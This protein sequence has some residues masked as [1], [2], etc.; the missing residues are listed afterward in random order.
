MSETATE[1]RAILVSVRQS[2]A[3]ENHQEE[4]LEELA[5]LLATLGVEPVER[6][7]VSVRDYRPRYLV[8]SGKADEIIRA[9]DDHDA[10]MIVF[11]NELSPSQQ[12]N[13]ERR[14]ERATLDRQEVILE[15]FGRH[16]GTR[17]AR[18]QVDLAWMQYQLPR[19]TR[20]WTHLS[21]QRGGRRGTRGEGETQ[22]EADRRT[23]LARIDSIRRKLSA[24]EQQ[25]EARR[26]QRTGV[27]VPT[28]AI[29]GYTN[30]G[31]SSLL[32]RLS[33]AGVLV[34][35]QLFA[36]LDP[37]T[38][39]VGLPN[40]AHVLLTDTVGFIRNLPH[41]LVDAF[42]S[43]L[44]E[45]VTADFLINVLDGS[46]PHVMEH[47][48]TTMSVLSDL[49][50]GDK[51]IV[52]VVNKTD[53]PGVRPGDVDVLCSRI[54]ATLHTTCVPCS[55]KTGEG[56]E[57]L[58]EA[59]RDLVAGGF[60]RASYRLPYDRYDLAALAHRTGRVVAEEH[61][62]DGIHLDASLPPRTRNLLAPYSVVS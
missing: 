26:K 62:A 3:G 31:K 52:T 35:D 20:A 61:R 4:G 40:A 58:R 14:A 47:H 59:V 11:D 29:V 53:S 30:A 46:S 18:L 39:K 49:G 56:I 37:T 5:G 17:E 43:T 15:I 23:V 33:G 16:A 21:R 54:E 25:R 27:P 38:R 32:N 9:A 6:L 19:L 57:E 36:T 55:A 45:T 2:R 7:A 42:H 13:W 34:E 51:P 22:L 1:D 24:V 28:G 10:G 8:G 44:E 60:E 50:A 48:Q 12:R 41:Q